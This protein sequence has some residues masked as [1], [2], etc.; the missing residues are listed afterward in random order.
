[1]LDRRFFLLS[2]IA[3][4]PRRNYRAAIIGHTG[5]GDY[6]HSWDTA[7]KSFPSIEVVA[8]ADP[9]DAGRKAAKAR[10]GALRDYRDY[11]QMLEKEK[12]DL[13][14]ICPRWLDQRVEMVTAAAQS[15]A[16]VLLEKPFARNLEDADRMVSAAE[17][18]RI[19]IQVGHTARLH[20]VTMQVGRLL[21]E[22]AIGELLEMRARGKEDRRA[23]GEDLI[24][25]GTHCFDL[26]RQF[27]GDPQ[28]VF[29][30]LTAAGRDIS[31][32]DARQATEPVGPVAGDQVAAMFPFPRGIH[33]YFGSKA[34]DVRS[35]ERFGVTLY[36]S[37][38]V[39]WIPLTSVPSDPAMILRGPSW[40]AGAWQQIE[41]PP[42]G[43]NRSREAAN[44]LMVADLLQAIEENREPACSARDGLWTVE[45]VSGI[46]Q[47]HLAG[48]RI[49]FPL[50]DR[51]PPLLNTKQFPSPG[52]PNPAPTA[53]VRP[54]LE[55]SRSLRIQNSRISR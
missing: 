8:L 34:S 52:P 9:D 46:Y 47:S 30:H 51:R 39:I 26:M 13:A 55:P 16:H 36:G 37:K 15:G 54:A 25:L 1:M 17:A 31:R 4:Q 32:S 40:A 3:F 33:G 28:W 50:R 21:R 22:G 23:G 11:R 10:S 35:G 2:A 7:W 20:P 24:V 38:G 18:H 41:P 6:G 19:R 5:H 12:P 49:A 53:K 43:R 48:G 14:A 27:A 44:A 29:A 45:M 42:E